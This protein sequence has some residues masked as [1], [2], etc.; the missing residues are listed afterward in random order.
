MTQGTALPRE[1][2]RRGNYQPQP[3]GLARPRDERERQRVLV[4]EDNPEELDLYGKILWY[5][6]FDVVYARDGAE[7]L[8]CAD[9]YDPDLVLLDL[10]LPEMNGLE[11]CRRLKERPASAD[12]PVV[13]LTARAQIACGHQARRAGCD[14]Y[15]EKPHSPLSVLKEVER[16][17]G[18]APPGAG[19]KPP[20]VENPAR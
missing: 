3:G 7:G 17:I 15:L 1:R 4:V 5:N 11:L 10:G 6:G 19:G 14:V 13:V 16:L 8:R 12:L 18:P 9:R 20:E 2:E